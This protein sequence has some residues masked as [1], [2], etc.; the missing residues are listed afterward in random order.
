LIVFAPNVVRNILLTKY[1]KNRSNNLTR[2]GTTTTYLKYE[3]INVKHS[4]KIINGA[5]IKNKNTENS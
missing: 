2:T 5:F 3:N 1:I 4:K